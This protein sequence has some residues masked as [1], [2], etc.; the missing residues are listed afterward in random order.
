MA[1]NQGG[2]GD[3]HGGSAYPAP[4]PTH[5]ADGDS[6]SSS[7]RESLEEKR[8]EAIEAQEEY[9]EELEEAYDD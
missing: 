7:D 6:I 5:D 1:P 2:Y 3:L 4:V 9:Q 8:E